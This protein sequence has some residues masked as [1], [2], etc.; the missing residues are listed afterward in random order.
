MQLEKLF[1][2]MHVITAAVGSVN[3]T[4]WA[5][6]EE[7][8]PQCQTTRRCPGISDASWFRLGLER[9]LQVVA[10]GRAFLQQYGYKLD[11]CPSL[12]HYF[13]ALKSPRRLKLAT[14]LNQ[15]LCAQLAQTLPDPLAQFPE[16]E[17]F[18]LYAGDGHWHGAA[19]HDPL[20][21]DCKRA[22]G[23]FYSL[24]LRRHTLRHLAVGEGKKEHDMHVLKRIETELLRQA[25]PK[26]QKVLYV[27]DKAGIDF[28]Q[29]HRWKGQGIYV[30]SLEKAN[31]SLQ[32]Q[33]QPKW[34]RNDP[35]NAGIKSVDLVAGAAGVLLR[36]IV[37]VE[38]VTGEELVF[39]TSEMNI[40]PGVIAFLYKLRWDVEK[41][42]DQL[43]NK[44]EEKH[45][46]ATSPIAKA[47]QATFICLLHNVL[48]A[49]DQQLTDEGIE[50]TAEQVRKAETTLKAQAQAAAAGREIPAHVAAFQRIT[51]RSVKMLRWLRSSLQDRLPWD[52]A[53]PR[54]R[55]LYASL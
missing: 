8:L 13:E 22:V 46:W 30:I 19:A 43:K 23:H 27:W 55:T 48:L 42:F 39:I 37:Y 51:Q 11:Q 47:A 49:I 12:G 16:L 7:L 29:W 40:R 28:L 3:A 38:P 1:L 18:D 9:V 31:M 35:V 6:I 53:T 50:N 20:Q 34:D 25:A 36:R 17:D 5:P 15:R 24:D 32:I 4:F 44:L 14:E 26:G 52:T 41:V 33:G 54:L 10:S 2:T 45:A 21:G